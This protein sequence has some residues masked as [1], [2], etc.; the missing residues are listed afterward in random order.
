V[1]SLPEI[2]SGV[3]AP[4]TSTTQSMN[5][6]ALGSAFKYDQLNRIMSSKSFENL[7]STTNSWDNGSG[8]PSKF[9][10]SYT[11]DPNGNI[12][13]LQRFGNGNNASTDQFDNLTYNY[14]TLSGK[15]ID[16]KLLSV[17]DN[18]AGGNLSTG[19]DLVTQPSNNYQYDEIG[20]LIYD[21]SEEIATIEWTVSGKIS[22]IIRSQ[23]STK[24]DLEFH[25]DPSGNR[26]TKIVKPA[27][28]SDWIWTYYFRD[29]TGN[30]MATYKE[31]TEGTHPS[32][33]THMDL[34]ERY[35][36]GSSRIGVD[37]VV[38]HMEQSAPTGYQINYRKLGAKHFEL[39]NHLG[40]VMAVVTDKKLPI[41]L[42]TPDQLTDAFLPDI[43]SV[44]DYYPG[45]ML[46]PGRN[47][48]SEKYRFG[49]NRHERDDEIKGSGNH[50][51][52]GD[53]GMDP[54]LGRRWIIDPQWHRLPGQSPY[55]VNNNNPISFTDPDGEFGLL[56]AAIGAAAGFT[57]GAIKYGFKGDNWKKT[58][59]ATGA[60]TLA[61]ATA[62][63]GTA[64]LSGLGGMA[65]IG[66]A[67]T[68]MLVGATGIAS[69]VAGDLADQGLRNVFG[70]QDGFD[71]QAFTTTLQTSL[72]AALLSPAV[73][74]LV[75]G[76]TN[77]LTKKM[78]KEVQ[79]EATYQGQK[80]W[81]KS[82]SKQLR[83]VV[84]EQGGFISR[85]NADLAAEKMLSTHLESGQEILKQ[86][87]DFT[88]KS[89]KVSAAYG[90]KAVIDKVKVAVD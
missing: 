6:T 81:M 52:W 78:A 85:K 53:Y 25:Y 46:I 39:T 49:F 58:L 60:G 90:E 74:K 18:P 1:N 5:F 22:K 75:P 62:G 89:V 27:G 4:V 8:D 50:L 23:G 65:V 61:G 2:T 68:A 57:Y 87:V 84:K 70:V 67:N 73:D 63:L 15:R 82:Y 13:S 10:T 45:G 88:N 48:S 44:T 33:L 66:G 76:A 9:N 24:A 26:I 71:E 28:A 21:E 31:Y 35:I 3:I 42:N 12:L 43:V 36:Y 69:H 7:S 80:A 86:T 59:A 20:N 17:S 32:S 19:E 54:R 40:N 29:A 79:A 16:N 55:S 41:D 47:F 30:V 83:E 51:T 64:A 72:P 56:G 11:Y 38:V 77:L 14:A 37:T 34:I